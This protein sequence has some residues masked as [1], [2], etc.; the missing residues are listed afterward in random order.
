MKRR[1]VEN[2]I[3]GER[4]WK[5]RTPRLATPPAEDRPGR[6]GFQIS[7]LGSWL[8]A[9]W[10]LRDPRAAIRS[11]WSLC[12][13][14]I[15]VLG[16]LV[17]ARYGNPA[18]GTSG[19]SRGTIPPSSYAG[20]LVSTPNPV[21]TAGNLVVTGNVGAGKAFR[22]SVPYSSPTSF[23]SPLG[24]TSLDPFLRYSA[25]PPEL[26]DGPSG[27]TPFYSQTGTVPKM[28]PGYPGVFAPGSPRIATPAT[29][30]RPD[31]PADVM[32]AEA[33]PSQTSL[34]QKADDPL[35]DRSWSSPI[36]AQ[37]SLE[38]ILSLPSRTPEEVRQLIAGEPGS[39]TP[40][41][42]LSSQSRPAAS[43][44]DYR[45][46]VEQLQRDFDRV[47]TTASQFDQDPKATRPTPDLQ[48][49]GP[50]S[51]EPV[52]PL[53]STEALRRA[54]QPQSQRQDQ[55][56]TI[57]PPADQDLMTRSPGTSLK[58]EGEGLSL[59]P[60]RP[61][62]P[63]EGGAPFGR[64]QGQAT[65]GL[66]DLALV[67]AQS[68]LTGAHA[69]ASP[70]SGPAPS[71]S[72]MAALRSRINAIFA[73]ET[74]GTVTEK[75]GD[76][77]GKLPAMQRLEETARAFD[78]PGRL[79]AQPLQDSRAATSSSVEL[80][81]APADPPQ[82]APSVPSQGLDSLPPDRP[83]IQG[84]TSTPLPPAKL[85]PVSQEKFERYMKLAQVDVQQRRYARAAESFALAAAYHPRDARPQIGRSQALLAAGEYLGSAAS[86]AKAIE[87]DP[88]LTL[89][90]TRSDLI[91]AVGG[92][93]QF[94]QRITA[95]E[96]QAAKAAD[97][98]GLQL[99][100]AYIYRQMDRP[101]QAR[102]AVRAAK[103]GLR[104]ARSVDL[105]EAALSARG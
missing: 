86:L 35:G 75:P 62:T 70:A 15:L 83:R 25:V 90:V 7:D 84:Q 38:G 50:K 52:Q 41:R 102:E 49:M 94:I 29:Q 61:Q 68:S 57:N 77:P 19:A 96:Q 76:T 17:S 21:D 67:P 39:P 8:Q 58:A 31:Q 13:F 1:A 91:D 81:P 105:L 60:G 36:R 9:A 92:P 2:S 95:V 99:L 42:V 37:S 59:Y 74:G 16:T 47:K 53:I 30:L 98:P 103:K 87:L 27:Y 79:L 97:T 12:L 4:D 18:A 5:R 64:V 73:S 14:T 93:D 66:S 23:K 85:D 33:L 3:R 20:S 78:A 40:E 26:S 32:L 28:Q 88:P 89:A 100:L 24:S 55:P 43:S 46:Q 34:G 10:P 51:T 71:A 6:S 44:E 72:E 22:G 104:A 65:T 80:V 56:P 45:R 11:H 69:G 63:L 82:T 54:F 101:E 48:T